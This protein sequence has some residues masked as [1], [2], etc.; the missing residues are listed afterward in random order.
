[1]PLRRVN[2]VPPTYPTQNPLQLILAE[3]VLDDEYST[4]AATEVG[5]PAQPAATTYF[6]GEVTERNDFAFAESVIRNTETYDAASDWILSSARTFTSVQ[7]EDMR[8]KYGMCFFSM[9]EADGFVRAAG[10]RTAPFRLVTPCK[11]SSRRYV[12]R[13]CPREGPQDPDTCKASVVVQHVTIQQL[14]ARSF[15]K[16]ATACQTKL[17]LA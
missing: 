9:T 13:N 5:P 15:K 3:M 14:M 17:A 6:Q 4:V 12:C 11:K 16:C 8:P 2:C 1:M 10:A 7:D